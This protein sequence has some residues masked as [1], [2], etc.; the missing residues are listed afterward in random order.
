MPCQGATG[1]FRKIYDGEEARRVKRWEMVAARSDDR[2][3]LR[4]AA[5][6]LKAFEG[7]FVKAD[8]ILCR[9][10]LVVPPPRF[11]LVTWG[12]SWMWFPLGTCVAILLPREN[13]GPA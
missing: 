10:A 1:P 7:C 13:P 4:E 6:F 11:S 2:E 5:E 8:A 3:A 12:E 9:L